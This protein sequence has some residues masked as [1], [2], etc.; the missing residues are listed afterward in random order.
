MEQK[1][2]K[3]SDSTYHSIQK[4][5]KKYSGGTIDN[6]LMF[7]IQTDVENILIE[8]DEMEKFYVVC[9]KNT[10]TQ[11]TI[12]KKELHAVIVYS[13]GQKWLSE[14]LTSMPAG[15]DKK[16]LGEIIKDNVPKHII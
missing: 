9:D 3:L 8:S 7:R 15:I 4:S 10:N 2:K 1:L 13:D 11:E 12:D 5:F 14:H 16:Q 6:E